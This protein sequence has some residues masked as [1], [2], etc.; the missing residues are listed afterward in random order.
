MAHA[1]GLP[2]DEPFAQIISS[3]IGGVGALP[4]AWDW[5]QRISPPC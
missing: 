5:M 2:N 4:T 3:Q 1:T